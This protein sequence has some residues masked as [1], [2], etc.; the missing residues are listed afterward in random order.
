MGLMD[1]E[2]LIV[3]ECPHEAAAA[4]LLRTALNDIGLP[5]KDF[6]TTVVISQD[7]A[8]RRGFT[9]SPAFFVDG[10]DLFREPGHPPGLSCRLYRS[11]GRVAGVPD[12]VEL[13]R[14][15]KR[16]ADRH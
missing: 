15:L 16:A 10:T 13:R 2:L 3:R 5:D 9:G 8:D 6:H 4:Q 7:D 12:L 11:S 14:A 1:V